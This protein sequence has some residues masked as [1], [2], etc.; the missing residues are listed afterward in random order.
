MTAD[1]AVAKL[2]PL[3]WVSA[4]ETGHPEIDSEHRDLLLDINGL[5]E[6]LVRGEGWPP[7]VECS[8][9]L[10]DSCLK[11][12][13]DEER[14]LAKTKYQKLRLHKREHR[15]VEQQL[16]NILAFIED[17]V[18]PSRAEIEAVLLLRAILVNHFFCFDIEYKA[19]LLGLRRSKAAR[20]RTSKPAPR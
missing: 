18:S 7:V 17:V 2:S 8:R 9:R 11:H 13:C 14:T 6:L 10:R 15:S 19:Y 12:F 16:D 1:P 5:S 20:P 4:F 3:V